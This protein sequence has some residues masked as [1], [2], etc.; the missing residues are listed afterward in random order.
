MI[1]GAIC[2]A[3]FVALFGYVLEGHMV[4]RS[5]TFLEWFAR[6][7]AN[8]TAFGLLG[9]IIGASLVYSRVRNTPWAAKARRHEG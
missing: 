2:G 6:D 7:P 4:S 3:G 5:A 9:A 8:V 1:A